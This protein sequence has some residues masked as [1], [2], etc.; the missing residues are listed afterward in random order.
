[1]YKLILI[2]TYLYKIIIP[3]SLLPNLTNKHLP[4]LSPLSCEN[5]SHSFYID[6]IFV[7]FFLIYNTMHKSNF[8]SI[9]HR[10]SFHCQI[11]LTKKK[12]YFVVAREKKKNR[13]ERGNSESKEKK[14]R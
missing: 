3:L 8:T 13:K 2:Y 1:M 4:P 11:H 14:K 5:N 7:H 12:K 9:H 6:L 10:L